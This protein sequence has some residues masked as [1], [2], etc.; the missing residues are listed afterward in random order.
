[1]GQTQSRGKLPRKTNQKNF[2]YRRWNDRYQQQQKHRNASVV[3]RDNWKVL[4]EM[5]F[6]RLAKLKLPEIGNPVDL[7]KAGTMELY[8]KLY[9]R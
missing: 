8:D 7:Y 9:D 6:P 3:V 5:D 1:M 4:E 2:G